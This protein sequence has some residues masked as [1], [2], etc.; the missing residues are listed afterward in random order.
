MK[1]SG[2]KDSC[3]SV[4]LVQH[5]GWDIAK[6]V[7]VKPEAPDSWM[8]HYPN[9]EWTKLQARAMGLR[10]VMV[11]SAGDELN[12]LVETL[13]VAKRDEGIEGLVTGAVASEYQKT[14]F[15]H[16]CD[17]VGLKGFSPIWHK[18]PELLVND[19][20]E[21]GFRIVMSSVAAS[22]LD[23]S[24][25]GTEL[26]PVDW[27][28]LKQLSVL[29]GLHLSGE[30]GEYETFVVGAPHFSGNITILES[31]KVWDGQSGRL[32]IKKASLQRQQRNNV[33]QGRIDNC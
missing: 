1:F 21:A 32:I 2:G 25:L 24:W 20:M 19:L 13:R 10:Q 28:K 15:D 26:S 22:G 23:E 16:V 8:F 7:T 33:Q 14:R 29:R 3:Y 30:G 11:F 6:L 12:G 17:R 31:E 5:Q 9:V 27:E 4:W 18:K